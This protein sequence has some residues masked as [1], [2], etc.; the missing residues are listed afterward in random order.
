MRAVICLALGMLACAPEPISYPRP[1]DASYRAA[2][3]CTTA[4]LAP[5]VQDAAR[6]WHEADAGVSMSTRTLSAPQDEPD[7]CDVNVYVDANLRTGTGDEG[8]ANPGL[9]L[10]D[11][12]DEFMSDASDVIAHEFGHLLIGGMND[13]AHSADTASVMFGREQAGEQTITAAD[14]AKIGKFTR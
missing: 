14:V 10:V 12:S 9:I 8:F 1:G 2:V 13:E 3:V 7:G 6:R 11:G 5:F 4:E